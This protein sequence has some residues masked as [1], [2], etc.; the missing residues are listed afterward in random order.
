M[1]QPSR[2]LLDLARE[3]VARNEGAFG[4]APPVVARLLWGDEEDE[5]S[6]PHPEYDVI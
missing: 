6:L 4:A 2:T 5:R 1:S 3:N